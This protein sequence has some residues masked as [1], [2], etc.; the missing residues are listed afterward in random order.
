MKTYEFD[1]SFVNHEVIRMRTNDFD[2]TIERENARKETSVYTRS[3]EQPSPLQKK[4]TRQ[5]EAVVF[6]QPQ[7]Y[8]CCRLYVVLTVAAAYYIYVSLSRAASLYIVFQFSLLRTYPIVSASVCVP[9]CFQLLAF[10]FRQ[11]AFS[12]FSREFDP[13]H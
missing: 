11:I 3:S 9:C 8:M 2:S 5:I 10:L 6:T 1:N 13:Q 4:H 12:S 7:Y